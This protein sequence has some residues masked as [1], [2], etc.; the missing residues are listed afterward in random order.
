M[1]TDT[2]LRSFVIANGEVMGGVLTQSDENDTSIYTF[3]WTPTAFMDRT[4]LFIATD[5]L[6]A[7]AQ[8]EPRI[9]FCSCMNGGM[10][11]LGGILDQTANP[12]DLNCICNGTGKPC[13]LYHM[14]YMYAWS[15]S[16]QTLDTLV[17]KSL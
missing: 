9:E 17:C 7:T 4:I 10:C 6:N 16:Q 12:L 14:L 5:D 11:T 3:T 2:N 15:L 13:S 1:V 8:Y